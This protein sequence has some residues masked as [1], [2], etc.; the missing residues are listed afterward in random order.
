[1]NLQAFVDAM[2]GHLQE[3]PSAKHT[4]LELETWAKP[5]G[6]AWRELQAILEGL[7]SMGALQREH[8]RHGLAWSVVKWPVVEPDA[9]APPAPS[10]E[11]PTPEE[12]PPDT[13]PS[14]QVVQRTPE[15]DE[16]RVQWIHERLQQLT[17]EQR[18]LRVELA[19]LGAAAMQRSDTQAQAMT[20][21]D[22]RSAGIRKAARARTD[23]ADAKMLEALGDEERS[24]KEWM[25]RADVGY[26]AAWRRSRSLVARGLVLRMERGLSVT[27]RRVGAPC[28]GA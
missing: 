14:G 11:V 20:A 13:A 1:M 23:A 26:T 22:K 17:D 19:Q 25:K 10:D 9:P 8:T 3:R 28:K 15:A 6:V 21:L 4:A 7:V 2:M 12:P 18:A 16:L 5:R 27:F 24:F